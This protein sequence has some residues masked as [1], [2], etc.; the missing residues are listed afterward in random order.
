MNA[1]YSLMGF[2]ARDVLSDANAFLTASLR[3]WVEILELV[4]A[5][6]HALVL[7]AERD[8]LTGMSAVISVNSFGELLLDEPHW[9]P[10]EIK[11]KT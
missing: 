11:Q 1:S 4:D 3:D 10:G 2:F 6:R 9:N 5:E 8:N 7:S